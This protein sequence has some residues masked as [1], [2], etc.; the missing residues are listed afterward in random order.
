MLRVF[1]DVILPVVLVAVAG[2]VVGRRLGLDVAPFSAAVFNLFNPCLVFTLI[3]GIELDAG[4][5]GRVVAVGVAV[6]AS[7]VGLAQAWSRLRGDD[8]RTVAGLSLASAVANQGN[9]GL[10]ISR[11]ALGGAGLEIAV[12][13]FV[14]GVVLWTTAGVAAASVGRGGGLR[15]VLVAPFRYPAV[16]AALAGT[17]VNVAN[18]RLPV[19]VEESVGTLADASIPCMLLVLGLQLHLPSRGDLVDPVVASVNRLLVGPL[20]AAPFAALIGLDGVPW[21]AVVIAAGMPTAVMVTV[22]AQ[23]LDAHPELGVRSV[24]VSTVA[25]IVTLTVLIALVT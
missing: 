12:V 17:V 2:G 21:K 7:N 22:V 18:V 23:Q 4:D 1:L 11:L 8:A 24:M 16:Y 3:A 15:Q 5:V 9:L 10:P 13:T 25:S 20:L 6:F 14:T 19:L